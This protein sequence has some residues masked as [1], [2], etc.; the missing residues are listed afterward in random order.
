M[1]IIDYASY[2]HDG[3]VHD[4][5]HEGDKLEISMES[6]ELLPEWNENNIVISERNT[7]C[8]NLHL[9]K[10]SKIMMDEKLFEEPITKN[11]DDGNIY[12][13]AICENKLLLEMSWENYPPKPREETDVF[14]IQ[15]EA[16]KIY[17][18]NIPTLFDEY[19]DSLAK[20]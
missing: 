14:T 1:N 6:A 10:I 3:I 18:E 16:E 5:K 15:I 9:E 17:W 11:Y 12:H 19:W 8:G 4:I 7:I 13:F 2:F 20:E